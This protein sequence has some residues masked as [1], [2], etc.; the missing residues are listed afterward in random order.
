MLE[1]TCRIQSEFTFER[2]GCFCQCWL[3]LSAWQKQFSAISS[4]L[5]LEWIG[6]EMRIAYLGSMSAGNALQY[7]I[8]SL[9]VRRVF[10]LHCILRNFKL[11]N[12]IASNSMKLSSNFYSHRVI[13]T[14]RLQL[15]NVN[16]TI[17]IHSTHVLAI[18]RSQSYSLNGNGILN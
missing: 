15:R 6:D 14:R 10:E 13:P 7:V 1:N 12:N 3:C 2:T 9:L 8:V 16:S 17:E 11:P 18:S 4:W 5:V